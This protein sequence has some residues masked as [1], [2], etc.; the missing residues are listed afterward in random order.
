[1]LS[2]VITDILG[3][4]VSNDPEAST[5]DPMSPPLQAAIGIRN[6]ILLLQ[7]LIV[8]FIQMLLQPLESCQC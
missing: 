3:K 8:T 1:M 5:D 6:N 4:S 7:Y 2:I